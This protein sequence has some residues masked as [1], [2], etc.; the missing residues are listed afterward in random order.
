MTR[1]LDLVRP[2]FRHG[3]P[4]GNPSNIRY[5]KPAYGNHPMITTQLVKYGTT[6]QWVDNWKKTGDFSGMYAHWDEIPGNEK[7]KLLDEYVRYKSSLTQDPVRFA[8]VED[9][10]KPEDWYK[11]PIFAK[12]A[13]LATVL[14]LASTLKKK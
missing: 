12:L 13:V 1:A 2:N 9:A 3:M 4:A 8:P 10:Y 5:I 11:K 7:I 14:Y 6:P